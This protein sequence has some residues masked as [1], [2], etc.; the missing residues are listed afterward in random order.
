VEDFS[1]PTALGVLRLRESPD[2]RR[3]TE[4]YGQYL[5]PFIEDLSDLF[6]L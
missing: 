4:V 3:E 1:R 2:Y 5:E 6:S